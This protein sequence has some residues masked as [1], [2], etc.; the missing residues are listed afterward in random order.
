MDIDNIL[1]D[2]EKFYLDNLL[3]ECI[4]RKINSSIIKDKLKN[5]DNNI[6]ETNSLTET[7]TYTEDYIY[8][9]EW[10]KL[11]ST[12]K[13]IKLR[14]FVNRLNIN[15]D[16]EKKNLKKD[17]INLVKNKKLTKKNSVNYNSEKGLISSIPNLN[18]VN[19]KY[20]IEI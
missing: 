19:N 16:T 18:V 14:E 20:E 15:N 9:K 8:K 12:H 4:N 2:I 10:N 17:L 7:D 6:T 5:I 13:I 11:H 3:T 1:L